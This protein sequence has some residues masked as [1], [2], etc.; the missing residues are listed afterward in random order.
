MFWV[1]KQDKKLLIG[2]LEGN[3]LN[4]VRKSALH[5][6]RKWNA[7][8]FNSSVLK[9]KLDKIVVL[10]DGDRCYTISLDKLKEF[11][12]SFDAVH[13]FEDEQQI[14]IPISLFDYEDSL[15]RTEKSKSIGMFKV[16]CGEWKKRLKDN[17]YG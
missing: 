12:K 16:Y 14:M 8:C 10:M 1:I 5:V 3:T 7:I 6:F 15:G 13:L 9:L 2:K 4:C 11:T 17:D